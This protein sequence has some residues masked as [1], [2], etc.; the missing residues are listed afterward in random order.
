MTKQKTKIFL[1]AL[2]VLSGIVGSGV[3]SLK[4]QVLAQSA[5]FL[6]WPVPSNKNVACGWGCYSGHVGTDIGV[7]TNNDT[8]IYAAASGT[9]VTVVNNQPFGTNRVTSP[10]SGNHVVIKHDLNG[11]AYYT[12]YLHLTNSIQV[13]VNQQISAGQLLGYGS[14]SG[15]TCGTQPV[16]SGGCMGYAGSYWHLHFQVNKSSGT[17]TSPVNPYTDNLWVK[18][19]DGSIANPPS[20]SD[21]NISVFNNKLYVSFKAN[22]SSNK[23]YITS[24]SDGT[25]F[26]TPATGYS[27]ISFQNSPAMAVFN[28]KLYSAFKANDSSNTLYVTS[29]SDGVNWTTPAKGYPGI[30]FQ[31]SPTMAAFSGSLYIAFKANDSSNTLYITSSNDGVNW[32]TPAKGYPGITFQG[33]PT[34]TVFNNK[35]YIAFKA[36][37]SSNTLYVTSSSDG[38]NWTT[39]AKGY[40]GITFQNN[41]TMAAF[42][43]KLYIAFKAN[44]SSNTLYI[45]SSS[46][47]VNWTT[48]AKGYPGIT[49]QGSPTMTV[50]N[51]KLY[52]AFK[53][54]DSSNT[55][56]VTSSSDGVNWTTPAKGYPGIVLGFLKT[57]R[58]NN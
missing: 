13:Q 33:S 29:S 22:D 21:P 9:V 6:Y 30:T 53:A 1:T 56:Y 41:P 39:P 8:P 50:F 15:L 26:I 40:P 25:N 57:Y 37:D 43:G 24:S 38:V 51:N 35:L 31:N 45:T 34:M 54:N 23:F 20:Q 28:G 14:N 42:N 17:T 48:P 44:D 52:I 2:A 16:S 10:A 11:T 58:L 19:T 18:N 27:G 7:S 49:F 46:D 32:T 36:N 4:T 12:Y 47:G 5:P 55:L 3:I